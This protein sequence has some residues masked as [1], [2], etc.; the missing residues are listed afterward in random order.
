VTDQP[1]IYARC[2]RCGGE[3]TEAQIAGASACP[4]C[5]SK[6]VPASPANDRDVRINWHE[7]RV[8]CIWAENWAGHCEAKADESMVDLI[9]T[10]AA[11]LQAQH[12]DMAPLTLTGEIQQLRDAGYS[13][14]TSGLPG[15]DKPQRGDA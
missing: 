6:G 9:H 1:T 13:V 11:R 12:P 2:V 7:L 4:V 15:G 10:I 3:F 8:L 5:G 14:E